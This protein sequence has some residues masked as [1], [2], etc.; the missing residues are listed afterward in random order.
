[1][2][3]YAITWHHDGT[4]PTKQKNV[5][6]CVIE[7]SDIGGVVAYKT[8]ENNLAIL[9]RTDNEYVFMSMHDLLSTDPQYRRRK[10]T[11]NGFTKNEAI[12]KALDKGRHVYSF[13]SSKQ[14]LKDKYLMVRHG[15]RHQNGPMIK[16]D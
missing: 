15:Q 12:G 11:F 13:S 4:S 5:C 8:K 1:M 9:K 14:L 7:G 16:N 10:G 3:K 2:E 6:H